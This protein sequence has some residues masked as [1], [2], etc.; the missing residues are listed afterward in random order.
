MRGKQNDKVLPTVVYD[1]ASVADSHRVL[2]RCAVVQVMWYS[3]LSVS[4]VSY[5]ICH[6]KLKT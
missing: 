1:G 5:V 3:N 4:S 6:C 2:A